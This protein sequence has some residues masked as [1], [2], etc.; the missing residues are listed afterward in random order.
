MA[1]T[2]TFFIPLLGIFMS[3]PTGVQAQGDWDVGFSMGMA[4]YMGDIGDGVTSRR[5]FIWDMQELRTRPTFGLYARR[6]LDRDGLWHLRADLSQIHIS[7]SDK[8][9]QYAARRARN[10]HFR[11]HMTE[12]SIRLERDLL[13]KPLVWARQRRAMLTVRGFIGYARVQHNPEARVDLNNMMYDQLVES[14]ATSE[15]QW[16]SL[17]ELQTGGV[18]YS[19]ELNITTL[20]FG[21]SAIV[22]GQKRG[23][24][25]D[26]YL[27]IEIGFRMTDTDYLD[28]ISGVYADPS[29]MSALGAALSSQANPT[30]L[31]IAGP[32]AG[33]MTAHSY[34]G[35]EIPVIR[36]NAANNDAYGTLVITYG[37]VL[38]GRS[39]SFN[40]N[41]STY[42]NKKGGGL[43]RKSTRMK[44]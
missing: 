15:G 12:G 25:A 14:G 10:L 21:L 23:G 30:D 19:D 36:G 41:R 38:N 8:D 17:P 4:N 20:P 6:K 11:N 39:Q 3:M 32:S 26:F 29:E 7:G 9:T 18:D 1:H 34:I 13:Q 42:G 37:K 28:D 35:D 43:F 27:G 33:S 5:G 22:T 31:N 16:H 44:F 24:A 2:R 40:R